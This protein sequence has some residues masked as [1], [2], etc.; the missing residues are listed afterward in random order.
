MA[1]KRKTLCIDQIV[2]LIRAIEKDEKKVM[3]GNVL[4]SAHLLTL[5]SGRIRIK[6]C[7]LKQKEVLVKE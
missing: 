2:T 7:R 4:D 1:S 5:L 3:S 6:Y